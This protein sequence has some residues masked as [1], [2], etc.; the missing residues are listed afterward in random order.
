MAVTR[1]M[2]TID[3]ARPL[4]PQILAARLFGLQW[5]LIAGFVGFT[6]RHCQNLAQAAEMA[7]DNVVQR[8]CE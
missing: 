8:R 7:D 3:T 2:V 4:G 5:K 1:V 6:P